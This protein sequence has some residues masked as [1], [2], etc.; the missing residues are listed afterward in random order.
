MAEQTGG[1]ETPS[2]P[3]TIT[4]D[5]SK[6]PF[7][8]NLPTSKGTYKEAT[9]TDKAGYEWTLCGTSAT[10]YYFNS[11]GYLMIGKSG[12]YIG[13]PVVDGQKLTSVS[14]YCNSGASTNV[15]YEICDTSGNELSGGAD[16]NGVSNKTTALTWN[17]SGTT[18][19]TQYRIRI[20]SAYNGQITKIVLNYN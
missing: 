7:T 16:K 4:L 12:S 10:G 11:T 20:T 2:E 8:T 1:G 9:Y 17:L 19:S 14:L 15:K 3:V 13:L 18:E 6:Q 5:C